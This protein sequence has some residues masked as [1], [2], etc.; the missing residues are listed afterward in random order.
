VAQRGPGPIAAN[1]DD[2]AECRLR[3]LHEN[4]HNIYGD[5]PEASATS[6]DATQEFGS[7]RLWRFTI[8]PTTFFCGYDRAGWELTREFTK[9]FHIKDWTP[10]RS[11]APSRRRTGRIEE[12]MADAVNRNYDGFATME[13]TFWAAVDRGV[14]GP[15]LF[16]GRSRRSGAFS[17]RL[18]R[19]SSEFAD[20]GSPARQRQRHRRP[21]P[22]RLRVTNSE[23]D[24]FAPWRL[25]SFATAAD[26]PSAETCRS[27]EDLRND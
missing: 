13:R 3:L 5:S 24:Y 15:D 17:A 19:K 20:H 2:A 22:V 21:T 7:K 4:E 8:L 25:T 9:H 12:V 1:R 14:T 27:Y 18:G 11:T 26:S 16:P 6:A 10:V 23:G